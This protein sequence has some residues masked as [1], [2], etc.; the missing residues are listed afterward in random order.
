MLTRMEEALLRELWS[1]LFDKMHST[2]H[3][4]DGDDFGSVSG[5][6]KMSAHEAWREFCEKYHLDPY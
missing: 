2:S 6:I 1:K 3:D 4:L 5:P